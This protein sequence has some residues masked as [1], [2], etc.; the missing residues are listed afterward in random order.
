VPGF[1]GLRVP[2]RFAAVAMLFL[3]TAAAWGVRDLTAWRPARAAVVTGIVSVAWLAEAAVL[4]FPIAESMSADSPVLRAPPTTLHVGRD[5]PPIYRAVRELPH[6]AVL[7]ELPIGDISWELHH[8]YNSVFHWRPLVN[9][10]S[11]YAPRPYLE[12]ADV[13]RNPYREPEAAWNRVLAAGI[14]HIIVHGEAFRG[15]APPAPDA[16]LAAH[17]AVP[18]VRTGDQAIYAVPR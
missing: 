1:D 15:D 3:M 11:G 6:D 13:L 7:L 5:V 18:I 10:Y 12:L 4:P 8:V 9:G 14:T 17:G 16:W 2:A